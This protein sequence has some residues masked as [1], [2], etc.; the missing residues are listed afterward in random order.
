MKM[1]QNI[2]NL[3]EKAFWPLLCCYG[4]YLIYWVYTYFSGL[5][6][7]VNR[8]F[9]DN[10]YFGKLKT[11]GLILG[12]SIFFKIWGKSGIAGLILGVPAVYKT[13]TF[14]LVLLVWLFLAAVMILFGK[15]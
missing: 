7:V 14:L 11:I 6:P 1:Y 10:L 8:A 4:L 3:L 13:V 15:S 9:Y 12:A 2:T 5:N